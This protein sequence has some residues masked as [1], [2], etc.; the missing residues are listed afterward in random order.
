MVKRPAIDWF[1]EWPR[2]ALC[3][4]SRRFIEE[5]ERVEVEDQKS[6]LPSQEAELQL[7]N[8][9]TEALIAKIGF[10]TGKVSQEKAIADAEDLKVDD[11]SQDLINY[12]KEHIP[13]DCLKV[14]K[15]HYL[16][17]ADF[18]P[19]YVRTKS[20]AAAGLCAW[21]INIVKFSEFKEEDVELIVKNP[22]KTLKLAQ[23]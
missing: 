5:A 13:Q 21:V 22:K 10:Q 7:K 1:H 6:K 20:F 19:N 17:D 11:S 2:E 3:S 18:N 16:K 4:G 14:I 15:E 9:D 8:Q 23:Y 12:D